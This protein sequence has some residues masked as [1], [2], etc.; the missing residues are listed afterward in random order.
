MMLCDELTPTDTG[1]STG[2]G[3]P[4]TSPWAWV[5]LNIHVRIWR[6]SS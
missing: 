5:L 1:A 3:S 6:I 4:L 2:P